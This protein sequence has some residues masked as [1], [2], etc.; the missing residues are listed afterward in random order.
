MSN[1]TLV[2]IHHLKFLVIIVRSLTHLFAFLLSKHN[3]LNNSNTRREKWR[4][5]NFKIIIMIAVS[6]NRTHAA[7]KIF[8]LERVE[9]N[10][11][12]KIEIVVQLTK[13]TTDFLMSSLVRSINFIIIKASRCSQYFKKSCVWLWQQLIYMDGKFVNNLVA[14]AF[15]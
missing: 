9:R 1:Q 8:F 4:T 5:K 12:K 7:S 2:L 6:K 14:T 11:N 10:E 15:C 3:N 13:V